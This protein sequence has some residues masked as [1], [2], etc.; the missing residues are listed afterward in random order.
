[1]GAATLRYHA[2]SPSSAADVGRSVSS[3]QHDVSNGIISR[4]LDFKLK[5]D[6]DSILCVF[7]QLKIHM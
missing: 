7:Q 6:F 2:G 4:D 3:M 5:V 1:M